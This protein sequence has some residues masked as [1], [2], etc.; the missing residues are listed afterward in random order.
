MD[1]FELT[2]VTAAATTDVLDPWVRTD[3]GRVLDQL[4]RQAAVPC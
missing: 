1:T 3:L 2:R 4:A